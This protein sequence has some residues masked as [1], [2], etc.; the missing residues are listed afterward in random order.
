M[1]DNG[2][3][4]TI[5]VNSDPGVSA[6]VIPH[7]SSTAVS[8]PSKSFLE[9]LVGD[10]CRSNIKRHTR[11]VLFDPGAVL[12]FLGAAILAGVLA[13]HPAHHLPRHPPSS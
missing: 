4:G 10:C 7:S 9:R 13:G 11:A 6:V 1:P 5:A 12:G 2:T 8:A 3:V